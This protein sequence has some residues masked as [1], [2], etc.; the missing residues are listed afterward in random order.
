MISADNKKKGMTCTEATK[1]ATTKPRKPEA[2][3]QTSP[4]DLKNTWQGKQEHEKTQRIMELP[5]QLRERPRKQ[6]ILW[7]HNASEPDQKEQA[8]I[9]GRANRMAA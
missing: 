5:K 3:M 6:N 2:T 7:Q 4:R 9:P 8:R 1:A